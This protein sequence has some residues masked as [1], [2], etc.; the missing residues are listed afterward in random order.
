VNSGN[1]YEVAQLH[2]EEAEAEAFGAAA[3]NAVSVLAAAP[4]C[5][6]AH[7]LSGIEEPGSPLFVVE[8]ESVA[9]H[10]AF[11]ASPAFATYRETIADRFVA[12]PT[13]RHYLVTSSSAVGDG[14]ERS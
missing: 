12:P 11:R 13:F 8:W 7:L 1:V 10:E 9:A 4:G 14:A 3:G 6:G 5:L 2:I